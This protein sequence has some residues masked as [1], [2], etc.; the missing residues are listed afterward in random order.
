MNRMQ[1]LYQ[2][3]ILFT[4]DAFTHVQLNGIQANGAIVQ[5]CDIQSNKSQQI[6]SIRIG[7][8]DS[9]FAT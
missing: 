4:A 1:H 5:Q 7:F 2:F 9:N 6:L 3:R 8:I